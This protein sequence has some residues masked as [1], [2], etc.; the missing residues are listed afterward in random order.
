MDTLYTLINGGSVQ[1]M[2]IE[3]IEYILCEKFHC[4]PSEL[5]KEDSKMIEIFIEIIGMENEARQRE[6]NKINKRYA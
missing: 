5:E 4:L 1:E 3:Y 2:P 6:L